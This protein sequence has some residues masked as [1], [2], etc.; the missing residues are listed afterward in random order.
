MVQFDYK[1]LSE[2][3]KRMKFEVKNAEKINSLFG[4]FCDSQDHSV[5]NLATYASEIKRKIADGL[6]QDH[7]DRS[8]RSKASQKKKK[9]DI[10]QQ[11][12]QQNQNKQPHSN[13]NNNNQQNKQKSNH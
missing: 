7:L 1:S 8:K 3:Q 12:K 6:W 10:Q 5:D 9:E 4:A 2:T 11:Q 13:F